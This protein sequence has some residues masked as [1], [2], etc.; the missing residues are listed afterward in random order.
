MTFLCLEV[1]LPVTPDTLARCLVVAEAMLRDRG[2]GLCGQ[3]AGKVGLYIPKHYHNAILPNGRVMVPCYVLCPSCKDDPAI[4]TTVV[5]EGDAV[6][7]S[8]Q[9]DTS[10]QW[11]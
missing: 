11:N 9:P 8:Y 4:T 5:E 1:D 10:Y 3:P 7:A 2:C 6:L